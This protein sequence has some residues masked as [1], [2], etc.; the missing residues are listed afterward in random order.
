MKI[1]KEN[2]EF[3]IK[4]TSFQIEYFK[5]EMPNKNLDFNMHD[6]LIK[7][8]EIIFEQNLYLINELSLGHESFIDFIG[9]NEDGAIFLIE[10]KRANDSRNRQ[11]VISQIGKYAMDSLSIK[12]ILQDENK[13]IE[14]ISNPRLNNKK[15]PRKIFS[16]IE[17]NLNQNC[18]NLFLLTEE[19]TDEVLSSSYFLSF[20]SRFQKITII[21]LQRTTINDEYYCFIRKFNDN[22]IVSTTR[23]EKYDL[24]QKL[25]LIKNIKIKTEIQK[26]INKWFDLGFSIEPLSVATSEYFTFEWKKGQSIKAQFYISDYKQK[27]FLMK[28]TLIQL[29]LVLAKIGQVK[30]CQMNMLI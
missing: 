8:R 16:K 30:I 1:Y 18:F 13:F 19:A 15:F 29:H 17:N 28:L 23:K 14:I 24:N 12:S 4:E 10:V 21:E 3:E 25:D 20:G 9:F 26:Q 6:Y 27:N 11:E 7:N 2:N 22:G 5:N